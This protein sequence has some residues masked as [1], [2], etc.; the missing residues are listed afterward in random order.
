[1]EGNYAARLPLVL[2]VGARW[3]IPFD[4]L[5][6]C[7]T[8]YTVRTLSTG[9]VTLAPSYNR[10]RNRMGEYGSPSSYA[11]VTKDLVRSGNRSWYPHLE[12]SIY[13]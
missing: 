4:T 2:A 9:F 3:T 5:Y 11:K 1:M 6:E 8:I 12:L 7:K 13:Q 10:V